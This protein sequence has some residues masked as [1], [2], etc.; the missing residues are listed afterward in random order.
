MLVV[1]GLV[2]WLLG[3][4]RPLN[5]PAVVCCLS[6][7]VFVPFTARH[8]CVERR[9]GGEVIGQKSY[10]NFLKTGLNVM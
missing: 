1:F 8:G 10:S 6:V 5:L 3:W 9:T 4:I 7:V 2:I